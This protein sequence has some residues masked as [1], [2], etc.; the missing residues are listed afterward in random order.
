M[1]KKIKYENKDYP[2]RISYYALKHTEVDL[3]RPMREGD[4]QDFE[5]LELLLFY[6]LKM[7]HMKTKAVFELKKEDMEMFLDEVMQEFTKLI[8]L[9]FPKKEEDKKATK[10]GKK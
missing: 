10:P 4:E 6:S 2:I 8:P 5:G 9:F 1:V 7:G 3:G